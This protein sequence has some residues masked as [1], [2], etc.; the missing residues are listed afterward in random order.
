MKLKIMTVAVT[1][2]ALT[3][4]T[5]FFASEKDL[6]GTWKMDPKSVE[7]L[8]KVAIK[9]AIEANPAVEDQI[10]ENKGAIVQVMEGIRLNMKADHT[11]ETVTPQNSNTG[12]W[13]LANKDRV[14]EFT[15]TDGTVRRDTIL[16]SSATNLRVINGQLKDT[17]SYIH[18]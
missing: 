16:Q 3:A 18:P 12:K 8:T 5:P 2:L 4:F 11:Y 14:L 7:K 10:E 6:I 15:K 17:I 13:V 9:K 1:A